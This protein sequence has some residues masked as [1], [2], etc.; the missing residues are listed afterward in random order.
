VSWSL[1]AGKVDPCETDIEAAARELYEE[2]G[3]AADTDMLH[4]V[5][6][7]DFGGYIFTSYGL[8][9]DTKSEIVLEPNEHSDYMWAT[10]D[11]LCARTDLIADFHELLKRV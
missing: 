10:K 7:S 2:T 3:I 4:H 5:N 1:P 9:L 8:Y 6:S 11:E